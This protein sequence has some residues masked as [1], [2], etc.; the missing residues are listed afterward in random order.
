MANTA[1][2]SCGSQLT[3]SARMDALCGKVRRL[4]E[5]AGKIQYG[6][7]TRVPYS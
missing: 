3:W 5:R 2:A 7:N 1:P 6:H 4:I